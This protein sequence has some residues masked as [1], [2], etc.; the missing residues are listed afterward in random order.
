MLSTC[1][2]CGSHLFQVQQTKP[3]GS[4]FKLY[5]IQCSS[6]GVP[7]GVR[8]FNNVGAMIEQ[9]GAQI[10]SLQQDVQQ[11]NYYISSMKSEIQR[12]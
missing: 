9:L 10:R 3:S 5:F 12:R 1:A 6:C 4:A 2:K 11:I 8:E 7:V